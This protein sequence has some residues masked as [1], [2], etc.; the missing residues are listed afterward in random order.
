MNL[1]SIL[2][3][4]DETTAAPAPATKTAAAAPASRDLQAAL[5]EAV[6]AVEQ[7]KTA[8]HQPSPVSDLQKLA[9]EV[10]QTD[11]DGEL[12]LARQMGTAMA[13]GFMERLE[14]Y[15]TAAANVE[16]TA[17]AE[18]E[19]QAALEKHA[20]EVYVETYNNTVRAIHKTAAEHF[21]AGYQAIEQALAA[22]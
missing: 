13:D 14:T 5:S 10:A 16:K 18:Y 11:R 2:N 19:K 21:L 8:S 15:K 4:L 6:T 9:A 20:E 12:K 7:A 1:Q 22:K 17:A 3:S